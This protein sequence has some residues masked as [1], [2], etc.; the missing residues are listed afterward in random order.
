M[1]LPE[2]RQ[3]SSIDVNDVKSEHDKPEQWKDGK[4]LLITDGFGG[5]V[6]YSYEYTIAF[7]QRGKGKIADVQKKDYKV[8][9]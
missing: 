1:T 2:L 6:H 7:D 3:P 5:G 9:K 8:L 4:L